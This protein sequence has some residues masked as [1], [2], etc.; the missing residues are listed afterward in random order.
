MVIDGD[1]D[2]LLS[3]EEL[4]GFKID[5]M[6]LLY[7][8]VFHPNA[9][10]AQASASETG[11]GDSESDQCSGKRAGFDSDVCPTPTAEQ[12]TEEKVDEEEKVDPSGNS[13]HRHFDHE[14]L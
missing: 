13:E 5:K 14:E 9:A 12:T 2:G 6:L 8:D 4:Y 11:G 7:P 3:W 1:E 10:S